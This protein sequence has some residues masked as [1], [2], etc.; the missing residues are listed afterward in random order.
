MYSLCTMPKLL[1]QNTDHPRALRP[2]LDIKLVV[3]DLDGS[4]IPHGDSKVWE[5]LVSLSRSLGRKRNPVSFTIA[6]GRT[7]TGART[8]IG[9]LELPRN[10][11]VILYNGGLI[12]ENQ[13]FEIQH[14]DSFPRKTIAQVLNIALQYHTYVL[15]YIVEG[16]SLGF[17]A[18]PYEYILG[19][20]KAK[21][22]THD[23]NRIPINWETQLPHGKDIKPSAILV[24]TSQ[25]KEKEKEIERRLEALRDVAMTRS[26]TAHYLEIRPEGSNKGRALRRIA[27]SLQL[28]LMSILALGDNDNDAEMLKAAGI[29]VAIAGASERAL[30]QADYMCRYDAAYGAVE[31]LSILSDAKRLLSNPVMSQLTQR[32]R[33]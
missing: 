20:S 4:L 1:P 17:E 15:A 19:W 23:F 10:T 21:R 30:S 5:R 8:L 9:N 25:D 7:L 29:G 24:D 18:R 13:T 33:R 11:L 27:K 3:A 2:F 6:T 28:P 31:I 12:V 16:P 32:K 14:N 22:P 26:G